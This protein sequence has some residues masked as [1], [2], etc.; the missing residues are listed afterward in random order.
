MTPLLFM[1]QEWAATSPFQYFTD[2]EPEL[3]RL[4]SHGRRNEFKHFTAFNDP[5]RRA[6]IPDPQCPKTF[7]RSHL[8]WDERDLEPH[9]RVL[10]LYR[11]AL[12]FRHED[13]VMRETGRAELEANAIGEVL[14]VR[15]RSPSAD[16]RLLLVSFGGESVRL[17]TLPG[18]AGPRTI[19]LA[20]RAGAAA[21]GTLPPATAV[22][23][24]PARAGRPPG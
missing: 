24:G 1:G 4:V 22:V 2:H 17:S 10:T 13:P 23:I 20:S 16:E 8:R 15:R 3:G 14:V 19:L 21:D 6:D 12:A 11:D 9:R 5:A 18:V 7:A